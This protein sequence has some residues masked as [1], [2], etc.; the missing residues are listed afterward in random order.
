MTIQQILKGKINV[1][2]LELLLGKV[3]NKSKEFIYLNPNLELNTRQIAKFNQLSAKFN[4][5]VPVAY[6]LGYKYFY[7]YKFKVNKNVLIPRPESEWLVE[8]GLKYIK[9]LLEGQAK[10]LEIL[11]MGTGSGCLITTLELEVGINSK[12][13]FTAADISDKALK[14]TASNQKLHKGSAK[15][16]QTNLFSKL[17][18][19]FDLV[20]ANLPYVPAADYKALYQ[21]L[22]YEPKLALTDGSDNSQLIIKFLEQASTHMHSASLCLLEI[23]PSSKHIMQKW[24]KIHKRYKLGFYKDIQQLTRYASLTL[25][26]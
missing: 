5:G 26:N 9:K 12:I 20:L 4:Q 10:R 22:R 23:D 6:L 7:G 1:N 11:D 19:K 2:E 14:V 24:N 16:V 3:L 8:H 15:L 25:A 17:R 18:G 13:R 21:G